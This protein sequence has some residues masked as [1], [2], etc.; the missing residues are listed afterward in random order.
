[1]PGFIYIYTNYMYTCK[2]EKRCTVLFVH[3]FRIFNS[4]A[5]FFSILVR[6]SLLTM[7]NPNQLCDVLFVCS[8]MADETNLSPKLPVADRT[9]EV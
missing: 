9:R 3:N 2:S 7:N 6:L 8:Q 1:M 5:C 4:Y